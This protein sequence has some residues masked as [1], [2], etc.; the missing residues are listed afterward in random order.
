VALTKYD[1][2]EDRPGRQIRGIAKKKKKAER[3]QEIRNI[4]Y[5]GRNGIHVSVIK[6]E[7]H[8]AEDVKDYPIGK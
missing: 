2:E 5:S 4:K 6:A 1:G 8:E 3:G 7:S